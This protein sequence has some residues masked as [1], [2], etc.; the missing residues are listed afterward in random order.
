MA[1]ATKQPREASLPLII[2]LV[3]FILLSIGLG[4]FVYVLNSDQAA[5]DAAVVKANGDLKNARQGEKEAQDIALVHRVFFGLADGDDL[6][7]IENIKEGDKAYQEIK[8]LNEL[9]KS[10]GPKLTE[11]A[12]DRFNKNVEAYVKAVMAKDPN[13]TP[14]LDVSD[15]AKAEE[16]SV[17]EPAA[18]KALI[19][20]TNNMLELTVRSRVGRDLAIKQA[21][22]NAAAYDSAVDLMAQVSAEYRKA[23]KTFGDEAKKFPVNLDAKMAELQKASDKRRQD[24][25]DSEVTQAKKIDD[26][27]AEIAQLKLDKRR[28]EDDVKQWK[29]RV[30]SLT[31]KLETKVDPF[32][33]DEPQGKVAKRLP[34]RMVEIDLGRAAGVQPGL[35]FSVLPYDFP[36]K[37]RQSRMQMVRVPDGRG[38]FKSVEVFVPKATI[39]VIEVTGDNSSRARITEQ[40]DEFRDPLLAGDLL[41]NS[42]WRKG[43]A[44]HVA[45]IGIF[46]INGDGGDDIEMVV[47][48]LIKMGIPVDAWFDMRTGKWNGRIDQRTRMV[49]EGYYPTTSEADP[50]RDAKTKVLAQVGQ[51]VGDLKSRGVNIVSFRDFFPRMGYKARTDVSEDRIN[52]A[53][54]RYIGGVGSSDMPPPKDGN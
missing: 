39:E 45:L 36:Q 14:K 38:G 30:Q 25:D 26:R 37:G 28:L 22:A 40:A 48:D 9:V 1:K 10:R 20:P 3:F 32:Q 53:F 17:W 33:F 6:K 51:A 7:N 12:A 41:Y 15:L 13:E 27:D 19:A 34:E 44:D 54:T 47:R 8:R 21:N 42:V 5:K 23:V 11:A 31:A 43:Q 18:G 4:V 50:N 52:Q 46:D 49:V 24:Y 35:T 2:S 16:F 29:D